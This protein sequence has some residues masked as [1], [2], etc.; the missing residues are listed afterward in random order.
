VAAGCAPPFLENLICFRWTV[1]VVRRYSASVAWLAWTGFCRWESDHANFPAPVLDSLTIHPE[2][3]FFSFSWSWFILMVPVSV[4]EGEL[5][6]FL[7]H[8]I[9]FNWLGMEIMSR[10]VFEIWFVFCYVSSSFVC[11]SPPA[12]SVMP[13]IVP[14]PVDFSVNA[15]FAGRI[16]D[17][18]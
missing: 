15:T 18:C 12:S 2:Y 9:A 4:S 1:P 10:I 16:Y 3:H 5:D 6:F 11:L 14:V 17:S 13:N 7:G 8:T